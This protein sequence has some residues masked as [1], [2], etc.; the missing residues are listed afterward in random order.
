MV[1]R[2]RSKRRS[3]V[4]SNLGA[5]RGGW[6]G[7]S[8]VSGR[9][10]DNAGHYDVR[11]E[12]VMM[13]PGESYWRAVRVRHLSDEENQGRHNILV[14]ALDPRGERLPGVRVCVRSVGEEEVIAVGVEGAGAS[15]T[16][17]GDRTYSVEIMG[18]GEEA[19]RS[20]RVYNLHADHPDESPGNT[21]FQ[22]SF[23]VVFQQ[24]LQ[25][26]QPED[27]GA[28]DDVLSV[29]DSAEAP[30]FVLKK[31][32]GEYVLLGNPGSP[33]TRTSML[34]AVDYLVARRATFGFA[35]HE[36]EEAQQ[37]L[38]IGDTRSVSAEIGAA[39]VASGCSVHR[40]SGDS[41]VVQ[42]MLAARLQECLAEPQPSCREP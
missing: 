37:V 18:D 8:G 10:D 30:E 32:I 5:A 38:I 42:E 6:T 29:E 24:I 9:P 20:E 27:A 28:G 4:E 34:L 35:P 14:D 31:A 17:S 3:G 2:N 39:L 21:R 7:E 15:Y 16:M 40:I 33:D 41:A 22:H 36:A 25:R 23:L 1:R 13:D 26:P 19:G 11:I 12:D